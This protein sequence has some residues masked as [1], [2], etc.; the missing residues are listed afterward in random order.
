MKI[1]G[2]SKLQVERGAV[3]SQ[4]PLSSGQKDLRS[5]L[6][7]PRTSHMVP[8]GSHDPRGVTWSQRRHRVPDFHVVLCLTRERFWL[9][10]MENSALSALTLSFISCKKEPGMVW[11]L[12]W[13]SG[14]TLKCHYGP[15]FFRLS[16]LQF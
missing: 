8:E 9:H 7:K 4:P 14:V 12:V 15:K 2:D 11:F 5:P 10:G 13:V 6:F 3:D 16:A 1:N